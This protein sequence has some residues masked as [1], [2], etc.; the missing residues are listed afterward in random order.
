MV[1]SGTG[2]WHPAWKLVKSRPMGSPSQDRDAGSNPAGATTLDFFETSET[3]AGPGP[4]Y[5]WPRTHPRHGVCSRRARGGWWRCPAWVGSITNTSGERREPMGR[6]SGRH[7]LDWRNL[8]DEDAARKTAVEFVRDRVTSSSLSRTR[9]CV[10][11]R[12]Q[13]AVPVLFLHVTHPVAEGF[14][15]AHD[16]HAGPLTAVGRSRPPASPAGPGFPN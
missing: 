7:S 5:R 14:R 3:S 16:P 13:A 12:G 2:P 4:T 15:H 9:R 11:L 10:P 6:K 1:S 8:A